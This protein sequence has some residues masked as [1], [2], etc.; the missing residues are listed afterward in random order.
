MSFKIQSD[1]TEEK[2]ITPHPKLDEIN[3]PKSVPNK[4]LIVP[5]N[6]S[7]FGFLLIPSK[8]EFFHDLNTSQINATLRRINKE[9]DLILIKKKVEESKDYNSGNI[10]MLNILFAMGLVVAFVMY[11]LALYDVDDFKEKFIWIPLSILLVIVLLA[12]IVMMKG[13]MTKRPFTNVNEE[14]MK[15]LLDC[16]SQENAKHYE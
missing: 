14:I 16:E 2:G 13:L 1:R 7:G 3:I 12:F 8:K 9:I 15:T 6:P 10:F 4:L 5:C 11:V